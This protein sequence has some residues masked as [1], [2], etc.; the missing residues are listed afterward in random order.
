MRLNRPLLD[1]YI[2]SVT[3][4]A[5]MDILLFKKHVRS[6]SEIDEVED[7]AKVRWLYGSGGVLDK[8]AY[9]GPVKL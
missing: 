4:E 3:L 7:K 5:N 1:S 8:I 6:L 2:A 9:R